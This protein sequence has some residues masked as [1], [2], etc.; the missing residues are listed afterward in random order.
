MNHRARQSTSDNRP[1]RSENTAHLSE[2]NISKLLSESLEEAQGLRW[3]NFSAAAVPLTGDPETDGPFTTV[4]KLASGSTSTTYLAVDQRADAAER[5]VV[6]KHYLR[7]CTQGQDFSA[8]FTRELG[9]ARAVN[10]PSI[11]KLL[12][13]GRV[14][15]SY[16]IATEFLQGESL[17]RALATP[18]LQSLGN[19]SPRLLAH[20]IAN[21]AE[22]MHAL[23]TRQTSTGNAKTVHGDIT[24]NHVFVLYDGQVRVTNFGTAWINELSQKR[25]ASYK[26]YLSP[27]QL[28][29]SAF[30]ARADIW[31]LGVVLWE[32]LAGKKL[33]HCTTNLEA[34]VE[35]LARPIPSPCPDNPQVTTELERIV[36]KALARDPDERYRSAGELALDLEAFIARSGGPVAP[37]EVVAWLG[38][39]FPNGADRCLGMLEL[40]GNVA[41]PLPRFTDSF[42][43][44]PPVSY[45]YTPASEDEVENT[46]QIYGPKFDEST[47]RSLEWPR[48]IFEASATT[49]R[50]PRRPAKFAWRTAFVPFA[51]AF[52]IVL[53]GF[54]A[55]HETLSRSRASAAVA[56]TLELERKHAPPVA[57]ALV[58][59]P[60][61]GDSLP[62]AA[63][64]DED[65]WSL[66]ESDPREDAAEALHVDFDADENANSNDSKSSAIA[67][68]IAAPVGRSFARTTPKPAPSSTPSPIATQPGAV[69][70]TTPGGGD[71]YERGRYL[72]HAPAEFELSPGWHTLLVKSGEDNRV[73]TV[74]VAAGSAVVVSLPAGKP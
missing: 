72:G 49:L 65:E 73:A 14:A 22:G 3:G 5:L 67:S 74:R 38:R 69:F 2:S 13:Y 48:G 21:L 31:A 12:D 29:G 33:F 25:A 11:C 20:L 64:E 46:T 52:A 54:V 56:P 68:E 10:Q 8:Q 66:P 34:V 42:G 44:A 1:L 55:G 71:V 32:L 27:E 61:P 30:D 57:A 39:L 70:V 43:S 41:T 37:T 23:H 15:G 58:L 16:Y 51:A 17:S 63:D 26:S 45:A 9:L 60:T 47:L 40:A 36:L 62:A 7:A 50:R 28:E 35:I 18:A 19:R 24:T 59:K 6:V 4:C 53:V